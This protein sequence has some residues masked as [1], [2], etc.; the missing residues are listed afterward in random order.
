MSHPPGRLHEL[1]SLRALAAIG[2]IGWH[3][4]HHF[5][6]APWA[7]F[8]A[9]FY[10]HGLILVDFFFVLSGFVLARVY[11]AEAR[12][13]GF[14]HNLQARI[15]R[16]YPLHFAMLLVVALMQWVLTHPLASPPFI[17]QFNDAYDFALNLVLLNRTGLERGFSFNATSW[18]ISTEFLVNV[19][20]LGA[21]ALPKKMARLALLAVFACCAWVVFHNGLIS[22]EPAFGV[23]ANDLFRTGFGFLVGV[24]A[25]RFHAAVLTRR[26]LSAGVAD[27]MAIMVLWLFVR[28]CAKWEPSLSRDLMATAILF[29]VLI[30]ATIQSGAF[31]YLLTRRPLVYL[32][33]ISFSIY[34]VHFPLQLAL[35]LL[36]VKTRLELPYHEGYFLAGFILA[37]IGV[38]SVTYVLIERPGKRLI[39]SLRLSRGSDRVAHL[40][41]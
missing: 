36:S 3:Y 39:H 10:R 21:I 20:F 38:A 33:E 24:A 41:T 37:S 26:C 40:P 34:M 18:S 23:V 30:L 27:G 5:G 6:Q 11:W 29:P 22:S 14:V 15:G 28:Y 17:Y 2:V 31:K 9:P 1:D 7:G 12:S 35:H 25:Q 19:V 4:T 32:G 16:M 8:M 13:G